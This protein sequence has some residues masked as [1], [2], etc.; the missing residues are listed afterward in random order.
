M[1][2]RL[3]SAVLAGALLASGA[4]AL[5][6]EQKVATIEVWANDTAAPASTYI[7]TAP[8]GTSYT[9]TT[10]TAPR[11]VT[12]SPQVVYVEPTPHVVYLEGATRHYDADGN[13]VYTTTTYSND[14][15][16]R[17]DAYD[18]NGR[19]MSPAEVSNLTHNVDSTTSGIPWN[20]SGVQPGNMGPANSKGQ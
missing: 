19:G 10:T 7:Y 16:N 6:H 4:P 20:G 2:I 8:S 5:A 11:V 9:Y 3:L 1:N 13:R 14:W 18:P 12:T 15:M 17:A